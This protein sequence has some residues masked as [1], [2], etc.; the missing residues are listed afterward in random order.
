M[1]LYQ[2]RKVREPQATSSPECTRELE[3]IAG[4]RMVYQVVW[5]SFAGDLEA[6]NVVGNLSCRRISSALRVSCADEPGKA[7]RDGLKRIADAAIRD[8][9]MEGL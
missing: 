6:L 4:F 2:R 5:A 7:V 3:E 9:L 1:G 8:A